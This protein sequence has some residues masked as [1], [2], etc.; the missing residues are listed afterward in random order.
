M[1][2]AW[3]NAWLKAIKEN[4]TEMTLWCPVCGAEYQV[5]MNPQ[6]LSEED[7]IRQT[8]CDCGSTRDMICVSKTEWVGE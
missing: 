1:L 2:D 8:K 6:C 7:V 5:Y 4:W 3:F